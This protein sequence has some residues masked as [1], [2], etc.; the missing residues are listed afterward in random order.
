MKKKPF[1]YKNLLLFDELADD[2]DF[3]DSEED[4]KHFTQYKKTLKHLQKMLN[5]N[6]GETRLFKIPPPKPTDA[7]W[8]LPGEKVVFGNYKITAGFF[9]F[10]TN[11][12][13]EVD[14]SRNFASLIN[15]NISIPKKKKL[16]SSQNMIPHVI[17][18]AELS[19]IQRRKYVLWHIGGRADE[20]IHDW[21]AM[22]FLYG[23]ERRVL[24]DR[25]RGIVKQDELMQIRDEVQRILELYG[26]KSIRIRSA[27]SN[28][29]AYLELECASRKL[30][31][32]TF[33]LNY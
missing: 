19:G 7:R 28:F 14:Y 26:G 33:R 22:L 13:S 27:Y 20:N 1:I 21:F 25:T 29:L 31:D 12:P 5:V 30:Y 16:D 9:Y 24:I 2:D 6:G 15:P 11:L 32:L 23:L 4:D 17:D 3:F 18:Y 8:A 10:G